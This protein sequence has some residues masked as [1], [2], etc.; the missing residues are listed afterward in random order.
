MIQ[1]LVDG[2]ND[3]VSLQEIP[4]KQIRKRWRRIKSHNPLL[5][6]MSSLTDIEVLLDGRSVIDVFAVNSARRK[7][8]D[9]RERK[10][11]ESDRSLFKKGKGVG[12]SIMAGSPGIRFGQ[13]KIC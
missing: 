4:Q 3:F 13:E 9:V 8:V 5:N 7:R 11:T 1:M 2:E 6:L 12:A 10:M